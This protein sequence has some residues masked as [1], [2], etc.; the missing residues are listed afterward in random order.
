M[1]SYYVVLVLH[2]LGATV[3]TGGHLVLALSVLPQALRAKQA[4]IVSEYESRFE[5]VGMPALGLQVVTGLWLAHHL[6]GAPSNWFED[7]GVARVVQVKLVLL[8]AT[9]T[10]ALIARV[11]V[12]PRLD[13]DN[14]PRLATYIRAV[15]ILAVLFVLAGVSIRS[16]GYPLFDR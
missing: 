2:V 1:A 11:R 5:R 10:L 6:L 13:D 14:L 3:W 8:A 15:T 9:A 16:G 7:N 12:I 4:A